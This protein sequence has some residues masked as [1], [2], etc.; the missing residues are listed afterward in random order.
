MNRMQRALKAIGVAGLAVWLAGCTSNRL[1][2]VTQS[3]IGMDVSGT[4]Q[5]PNHVSF[6]FDRY[7]AAIVPRKADG[8]AHSVYGGMDADMRWIGP[9]AIRQTFATGEAAKI[10]TQAGSQKLADTTNQDIA[11]LIFLTATTY[12]LNLSVGE[13][14]MPP[15]L[16]VGYRRTEAAVIPVPDPAQE[17]RSVYA[18]VHINTTGSTNPVT[19]NASSLGGVRIVQSFA[20]GAAANALAR[21]KSV[22][23]KLSNAASLDPR[24]AQ[25]LASKEAKRAMI[26]KK[27]SLDAKT[28][29]GA[30]LEKLLRNTDGAMLKGTETWRADFHGKLLSEFEEELRFDGDRHLDTLAERALRPN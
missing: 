7:E 20:T 1:V 14:S 8:E 13:Q 17:V 18:D 23:S 16:L 22:Q 11:P 29:D 25:E 19:T 24:V 27:V 4:A 21:T 2:F 30:S 12:G 5:M 6:S 3:S 9:H 28:V 26:L 10:A 15:N